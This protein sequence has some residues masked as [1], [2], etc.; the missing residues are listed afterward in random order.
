MFFSV[1]RLY[2]FEKNVCCLKKKTIIVLP[3]IAVITCGICIF[4]FGGGGLVVFKSQFQVLTLLKQPLHFN[5][6]MTLNGF[7]GSQTKTS[8]R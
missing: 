1:S 3:K 7:L 5:L 8:R 2:L 6:L 4:L